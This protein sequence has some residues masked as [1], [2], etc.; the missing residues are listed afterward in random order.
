MKNLLLSM[1]LMPAAP[2]LLAEPLA[3]G[4]YQ[5]GLSA[6]EA[7][8]FLTLCIQDHC[9]KS[10]SFS[11]VPEG[12]RYDFG[13]FPIA[14]SG[15]VELRIFR[16]FP[17]QRRVSRPSTGL[18]APAPSTVAVLTSSLWQMGRSPPPRTSA[19]LR[20][21]L[22]ATGIIL[23]NTVTRANG[24]INLQSRKNKRKTCLEQLLPTLANN[25]PRLLHALDVRSGFVFGAVA[26]EVGAFQ[27]AFAGGE[28]VLAVDGAD[29][30]AAKVVAGG[31]VGGALGLHGVLLE[32]RV[33]VGAYSKPAATDRQH[34]AMS[35]GSRSFGGPERSGAAAQL[36]GLA[37]PGLA[38]CFIGAADRSE[39]AQASRT[40]TAEAQCGAQGAAMRPVP[41]QQA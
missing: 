33:S 5:V 39:F 7:R 26:A 11:E 30:L 19:S 32:M 34:F 13:T 24:A 10:L 16:Y 36:L 22:I 12:Y 6:R 29:P 8:M 14:D 3:G 25:V 37:Y 17:E 41:R 4:V 1:L 38:L 20:W 2:A 23:A 15:N 28:E 9:Q 21:C 40:N 18:T 27:G 31:A 35:D